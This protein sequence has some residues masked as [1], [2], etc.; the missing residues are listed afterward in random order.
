MIIWWFGCYFVCCCVCLFW[1]L[2]ANFLMF[3][4]TWFDWFWYYGACLML[5]WIGS[6]LVDGLVVFYLICFDGLFGFND[7]WCWVF[8]IWFDLLFLCLRFLV[9]VCI[10]WVGCLLAE[11]VVGVIWVIVLLLLWL[12]LCGF[13]NSRVLLV[14]CFLCYY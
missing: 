8:V 5:Y 3:V 1:C 6:V 7:R 14:V 11:F 13:Y 9:I 4:F 2:G 10:S 12:Y